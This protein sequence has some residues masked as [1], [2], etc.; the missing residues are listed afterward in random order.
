MFSQVEA[1]PPVKVFELT[2]D[3]NK[4]TGPNKQNLGVG[5]TRKYSLQRSCEKIA[6]GV[7]HVYVEY[8]K[9]N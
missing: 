4:C 7:I 3:Y 9:S 6:L 5:G 1:A 8:F 2:A